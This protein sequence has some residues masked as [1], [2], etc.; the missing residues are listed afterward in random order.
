MVLCV[1]LSA[2]AMPDPASPA[3]L[4]NEVASLVKNG[5]PLADAVKALGSRGFSCGEGTSFEPGAKGIFECNR[6]RAPWWPPYGCIHRVWFEAAAPNGA[7]S[8]LQV[9]KPVCASF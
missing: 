8:N 9:L 7:I 5:M 2:C 3:L 4:G 1:A 6:S